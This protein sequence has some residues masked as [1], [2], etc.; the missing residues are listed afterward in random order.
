LIHPIQ[1]RWIAESLFRR[2]I[3]TNQKAL[4][5]LLNPYRF[6]TWCRV[7]AEDL[8][9]MVTLE[10]QEQLVRKVEELATVYARACLHYIQPPNPA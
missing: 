3:Q 6:K 5:V 4:V 9:R 8:N 10:T 2:A 7:T 1:V